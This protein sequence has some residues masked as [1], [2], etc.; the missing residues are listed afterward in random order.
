MQLWPSGSAPT[1]LR[2]R[3]S[4]DLPQSFALGDAVPK[5]L[6]VPAS[7]MRFLGQQ[8]PRFLVDFLMPF[9]E[10]LAQFLGNAFDLKIA[11]WM[12]D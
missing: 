12:I 2:S 1:E 7:Q 4:F 6:D 10:P 5:F 9:G 11:T 8:L 3:D